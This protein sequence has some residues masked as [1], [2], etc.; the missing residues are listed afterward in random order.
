MNDFLLNADISLYKINQLYKTNNKKQLRPRYVVLTDIYFLLFDQLPENKEIGKL[1]FIGD[2]KQLNNSRGSQDYVENLIAEFRSQ[3]KTTIFFELVFENNGIKD[4]MENV[5]R[6]ITRLKENFRLFH[7]EISKLNESSEG[8]EG[9]VVDY[10]KLVLLIK[11]KEDL[12]EERKSKSSHIIKELINLYQSV[13]EVL[14]QRNDENYKVYLEKMKRLIEK[15][16]SLYDDNDDENLG[17]FDGNESVLR[18]KKKSL[19]DLSDI[20][21]FKLSKSYYSMH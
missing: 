5:S 1:L 16:E 2:I 20:K 15:E 11:F 14:T 3:S 13:I 18:K 4:F 10:E 9:H 19:N 8:G 17:I 21:G 6:K 12:L 7:E